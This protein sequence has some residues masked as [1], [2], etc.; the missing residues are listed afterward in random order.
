MADDFL[1]RAQAM[2]TPERKGGRT[3]ILLGAM[4]VAFLVGVG[5]TAVA[6]TSGVFKSVSND[7]AKMVEDDT[8]Q[9]VALS[10]PAPQPSAAQDALAQQQGGLE[11]R[12]SAMEQR[13]TSLDLQSQAS[14]GNAARA[15]GLLIAFSA[16][17]AVERGEP[18]G[19]LENQL[20]LRFGAAEPGAVKD[21]INAA[22]NPVT[23]EQLTARLEG[24]SPV[25][26]KEAEDGVSWAWLKRELGELFIVRK[27]SAPSPLPEDRM[28]RARMRLQSGLI[29]GAIGEVRNLPGGESAVGRAWIADAQR[30]S[31]AMKGLDR[32]E[33][34]A[35]LE[36]RE[37][38][39]AG[40]KKVEQASPAAAGPVVGRAP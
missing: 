10:A 35:I 31:K 2:R 36:P 15:E 8:A 3:R 38:R 32:I 13:L 14:A 28:S 4:L 12:M 6:V 1:S 23:V 27:E 30:Y 22:R 33:R 26:A 19:Y 9:K 24:L 20:N 39:D 5:L 11:A 7:V 29:D 18:L 40:G 34:A 25:L 21:V 16:R 37:L 17:R